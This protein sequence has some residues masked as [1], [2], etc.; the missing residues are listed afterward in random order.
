MQTFIEKAIAKQVVPKKT[1]SESVI[2]RDGSQH[3]VLVSTAGNLTKAGKLFQERTGTS[4]ET[5]S[6]EIGQM[7][8]RRGNV[9]YIKMR[10]GKEKEVRKYD[11]ATS[12]YV[13]TTLGKRFFKDS[14]VEYVVKLP[15]KFVGVRANGRPYERDGFFPIHNPIKVKQTLTQAQKDAY[16]KIKVRAEHVGEGGVIAEYSEERVTLRE[17]AEWGIVEMTTTANTLGDPEVRERRL[18]VHPGSVSMLVFPEAICASAFEDHN[19]KHCCIRQLAEVTRTSVEEV[20]DLMD[21]CELEVYG[22]DTWRLEGCTS[23]MI[24]EYA[25]RTGRGACMMHSDKTVETQPGKNAIC[26]AIVENH[27]YFYIDARVRRHLAAR[28]PAKDSIEKIKRDVKESTTPPATEWMLW[29]G[30]ARAGHFW[31]P[32][33]SIDEARS[34]FL[35]AH[36]HPKVILKDELR[37]K[38]LRYTFTRAEKESGTCI[39]HA[40]PSDWY[41]MTRWLDKLGCG[42]TY[43]AESLQSLYYKVLVKLVTQKS[44]RYLKSE[45]KHILMEET[46]GYLCAGCG[47]RG[48][49]EWDHINRLSNSYGEQTLDSFQPLCGECHQ[50]KSQ[51][52]PILFDTDPLVSHVDRHVWEEYVL[53]S[54]TPPL[55]QKINKLSESDPQPS[56]AVSLP[57]GG[58]GGILSLEGCRIADVRR[59][60]FRALL[61]NSHPIPILSPLDNIEIFSLNVLGDLNFVTKKATNFQAQ[62]G[63]TGPGWQHRVQTEWLLYTRII[64]FDDIAYKITA[65]G[66]LPNDILKEPLEKM[67][68]AWDTSGA[69]GK[70]ACN[71][72]IG[73]WMLDECFGYKL[74]SSNHAGDAPHGALKKITY[75]DDGKRF[76]T[77]Y[78]VKTKI[79]STTTL[80]P[81]HDLC[82][83]TE[84]VR[85][86]QMLYCLRR[87]RATIYEI[88]TDSCLYR[89]LKRAKPILEELTF[90]KLHV[91]DIFEPAEAGQMR[92]DQ[93]YTPLLS[94]SELLVYKVEDATERDLMKMNPA[95]PKRHT[96]PL[97][98]WPLT[99]RELTEEDATAEVLSGRSLY[100]KGIAG[101][102]KTHLAKQLVEQLKALGKSVDV[103]AK[104]HTAAVRAGGV[105]ADHYV[106]RTIL[107]GA[108]TADVILVE[109]ISQIE[110]ALW[111][112]LNKVNK[113]WLLCGDFNQFPPVFDNWRGCCVPEGKFE[114]SRMFHRMAGGNCITLTKCRRSD[115]NLFDFYSSLIRGGARFHLPLPEVIEEARSLFNF[116]GYAKHNLCISHVK[117]RKLNREIN[118]ALRP[119]GAIL[120]RAKPQKGQLN[121]AQNMYIWEGIQLLGCTSAVKRG[122]RNNVLYTVI[123]ID[124]EYVSVKGDHDEPEEIKLTFLQVAALLRLSFARTYASVQGTEFSQELRCHDVTNKHFTMR[125]LFVAISRAKDSSKIAISIT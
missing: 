43:R 3:R 52:E 51:G 8:V 121:A 81:L 110:C 123:K 7:P 23:R 71:S 48:Q 60:R 5:Y 49:V 74:Y 117:R 124:D 54:R 105:T 79:L 24:F 103:I 41:D 4:L 112:Q 97:T 34:E 78:V 40:M 33:E 18:G 63:Y 116:E 15:A 114:N 58:A 25:R 31:V 118:Q 9:E 77:D 46:F 115:R 27:A 120:I 1:P 57:K 67:E 119:E 107:H 36:R 125:H 65:S 84:A 26:F 62:L 109:E 82:M 111:A 29:N 66:H 59:C 101:V 44:R 45:E 85:V 88:K 87:Q 64:T 104:C 98:W 38:S 21:E 16:I 80:R 56:A 17:G 70:Q 32:E 42:I 12:K 13:Y 68:T 102:G 6:Y 39:V 22:T 19:D 2:L 75:Y 99:W 90:N 30:E 96:E 106:R 95:P 83:A 53:S 11:P 61:L 73:T 122:I 35:A 100:I 93:L 28:K 89:P 69:L 72:M 20:S 10:G 47:A 91:R 55:V 92:L 37:I 94:D 50:Q 113:Q 86:G 108:C 14:K 76:I